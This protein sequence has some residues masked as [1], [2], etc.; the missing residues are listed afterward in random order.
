MKKYKDGTIIEKKFKD[1]SYK[2]IN[3]VDVSTL[4]N[5]DDILE[6]RKWVKI[7]DEEH[8]APLNY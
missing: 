4:E 5:D 7:R 1:M 2:E 6:F 3:N 8:F